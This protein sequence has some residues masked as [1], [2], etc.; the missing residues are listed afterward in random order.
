LE[1][2]APIEIPILIVIATIGIIIFIAFI[3]FFV[4][5][6][7]KK[8]LQNK[9]SIA[10]KEKNHQRELANMTI[11]VAELERKRIANNLHDDVGT[12]INLVKMNLS[13]MMK[14]NDPELI[15]QL[16]KESDLLLESTMDNV[17]NINRDLAPPV[18]LRLGIKEAI[19]DLCNHITSSGTV[20]ANCSLT[21]SQPELN[22]QTELQLFRIIT[23][24]A[25]NILKHADCSKLSISLMSADE[26]L[27]VSITHNGKGVDNATI[28][29]LTA[30]SRGL[31][32]KSIRSRAGIINAKINYTFD[33]K[34]AVVSIE[35][36]I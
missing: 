11:E 23:E 18:L 30:S 15:K 14:Q 1:N 4:L 32:L 6:Y 27:L 5:F 19:L 12:V 9:A 35:V 25:N 13:R 22:P 33:Q 10:E 24:I 21:S 36:P 28:N 8:A 3:I 16:S 17:R 29:T 2:Q 31:G 7:Q 26:K 34:E 20:K